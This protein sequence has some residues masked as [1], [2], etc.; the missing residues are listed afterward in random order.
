MTPASNIDMAANMP[1][2]FMGHGVTNYNDNPGQ[3]DPRLTKQ[4]LYESSRH[5]GTAKKYDP[6]TTMSLPSRFGRLMT[7]EEHATDHT[8]KGNQPCTPGNE[9]DTLARPQHI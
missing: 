3:Q 1:T 4:A 2:N 8:T 9:D 5:N 6:T 7:T